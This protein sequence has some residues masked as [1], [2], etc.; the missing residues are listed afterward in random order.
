MPEID[1]TH[2]RAFKDNTTVM[3]AVTA[4]VSRC[5]KVPEA[6]RMQGM[7]LRMVTRR[8]LEKCELLAI[9][10]GRRCDASRVTTGAQLCS[11]VCAQAARADAATP[12]STLK[13]GVACLG[14]WN[15]SWCKAVS[16][17]PTADASSCTAL[18]TKISPTSETSVQDAAFL[19]VTARCS[20]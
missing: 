16:S 14:S 1:A 8:L 11:S 10:V 7:A 18:W 9:G 2:L 20:L 6:H 4:G 12:Y 13:D 19:T 3:C 15:P 17:M 5:G